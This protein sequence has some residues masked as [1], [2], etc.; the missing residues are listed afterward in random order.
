MKKS[1]HKITLIYL[2]ILLFTTSVIILIVNLYPF[3]QKESMKE[4]KN[5]CT[6]ES[7]QENACIEIYKPVCGWFNPEKIQCIKYP[8][9]NTYSNSCFACHNEEVSYW[10]EGQCPE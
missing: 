5:F 2:I 9:A 4:K 3:S 1:N 10:T 6:P 8:C 7:R